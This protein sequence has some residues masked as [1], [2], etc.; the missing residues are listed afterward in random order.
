MLGYVGIC[1]D[2]QTSIRLGFSENPEQDILNVMDNYKYA[3]Q[4]DLTDQEKI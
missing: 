2:N 4:E 3:R 1:W